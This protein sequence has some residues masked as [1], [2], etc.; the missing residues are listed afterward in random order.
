MPQDEHVFWKQ[1][2]LHVG[3]ELR[4]KIV[5]KSSVDNPRTRSKRDPVAEAKTEKRHLRKL[6]KKFGWKLHKVGKS[7]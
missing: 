1:L 3:D 6:A 5:E 4:L 2:T 7:K